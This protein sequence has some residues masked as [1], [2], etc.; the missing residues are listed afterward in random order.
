MGVILPSRPGQG[1][2]GGRTDPGEMQWMRMSYL[3]FMREGN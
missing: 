2:R 3:D 1:Q